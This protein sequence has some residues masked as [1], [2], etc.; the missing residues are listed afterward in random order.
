MEYELKGNCD[1]VMLHVLSGA[2][3]SIVGIKIRNCSIIEMKWKELHNLVLLTQ[4][5][6]EQNNFLTALLCN[7]IRNKADTDVIILE[8]LIDKE[9]TFYEGDIIQMLKLYHSGDLYSCYHLSYRIRDGEVL[10]GGHV[11]MVQY[12]HAIGCIPGEYHISDSERADFP[13]WFEKHHHLLHARDCND[14]YRAMMRAYDKSYFIG[15]VELEYIMLFSILEMIFGSGNSEITYQISRG[16]S[17]LLSVTSDE[18]NEVYK[19]MKKL[20]NVRSKYVHNGEKIPMA[21]LIQLRE[22]VRRVLIKIVDLGYHV[23]GESFDDLRNKI[24]LGGYHTFV[25]TEK[26]Q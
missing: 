21:S 8:A 20:Y 19:Q 11:E 2:D 12:A 26:E 10:S 5:I 9:R 24:L 23:E 22:I 25:D 7:N 17:L 3:K 4:G 6:Q 16:T 14:A 18:M 13:G 1:H 15:V